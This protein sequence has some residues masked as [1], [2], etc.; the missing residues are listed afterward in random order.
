MMEGRNAISREVQQINA[1]IEKLEEKKI[2]ML[3]EIPFTRW[4]DLTNA[5]QRISVN[6]MLIMD[7][8]N[9]IS[10]LGNVYEDKKEKDN[11]KSELDSALK[12]IKER[13]R[14]LVEIRNSILAEYSNE[15]G[16]E[17][18]SIYLQIE[19][20]EKRKKNF[21]LISDLVSNS[22]NFT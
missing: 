13:I 8:Q 18:Q 15:F 17:L 12:E 16:K 20:L 1:S 3:R 10:I 7:I 14:P 5:L 11:R 19:A 6:M 22:K 21:S 9:E 2:D 4:T